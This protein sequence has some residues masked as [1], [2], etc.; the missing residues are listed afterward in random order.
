MFALRRLGFGLPAVAISLV[1]A[2]SLFAAAPQVPAVEKPKQAAGKVVPEPPSEDI[3]AD[4]K[5]LQGTWFCEVAN[6]AGVKMRV[7]KKVAGESDVVTHF[8]AQGNVVHAHASE[9][10]LERHGPLRVFT[11]TGSVATAGPNMGMR[12]GARRSYVYRIQGDRMIEA[13]GLIDTDVGPPSMVIWQRAKAD[14]AE[15]EPPTK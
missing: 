8:D 3:A 11:V 5:E 7:E 15:A 10:E 2:P 13:G 4:L 6:A 1:A 12:H 9:F 14:A